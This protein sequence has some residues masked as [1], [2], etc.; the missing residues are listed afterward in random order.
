MQAIPEGLL[1]HIERTRDKARELATLHNV[2]QARCDLAAAAHDIARALP[3]EALL[4]E[5]S[6][7]RMRIHPVER[8]TPFLLHG[9][10]ASMWLEHEDGVTDEDV[11]QAVRWHT[12]GRKAMRPVAKVVFLAD[13]LEPEKVKSFPDLE[14]VQE[15]AEESLDRAILAFLDREMQYLLEA[16]RPIHPA[17][18]GVRNQ[19]AIALDTAT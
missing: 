14:R 17:A 16:G 18:L 7:Y 8:H 6:R 4:T 10:I 12:T 2:D 1:R 13:K 11:I 3:A 15:L 19:L 5:A 9:R